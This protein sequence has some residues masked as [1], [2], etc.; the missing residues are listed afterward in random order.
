MSEVRSARKNPQ[1]F[2]R[3]LSSAKAG[4]RESISG[5][6]FIPAQ[7]GIHFRGCSHSRA[8]GNPRLEPSKTVH[9]LDARIRGSDLRLERDPGPNVATTSA[10]DSGRQFGKNS[11]FNERSGNVVENKGP[12][13]KTANES[14]NIYENKAT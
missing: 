6:A 5:I 7:A 14:G 3:S 4:E 11:F 12:L 2:P 9:G 10:L 1:S 13:L 8:G